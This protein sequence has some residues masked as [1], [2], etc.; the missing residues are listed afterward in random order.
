MSP[1]LSHLRAFVALLVVLA[2]ASTTTAAAQEEA[3]P[4][5]PAAEQSGEDIQTGDGQ[6]DSETA[7]AGSPGD[8][9]KKKAKKKGKRQ[10]DALPECVPE[11]AAVGEAASDGDA[12]ETG[13][14]D[15]DAELECVPPPRCDGNDVDLAPDEDEPNCVDLDRLN[16][17]ISQFEAA[18]AEETAALTEL[19]GALEELGVLNEQ[20]ELFRERLGDVQVRFASA[21]AD[22]GFAAIRQSI[23]AESFADVSAALQS[24]QDQL[25][26]QAVEAYM[27]G[28]TVELAT[29]TALLDI[30][31]YGDLEIA[32]E[33]A[34]VVIGDQV[35]TVDRVD[36][37]Q[38]GVE[39]L[40]RE[41]DLVEAD[42][43]ADVARVSEIEEQV[44]EL[45]AAQGDLVVGAEGEA[46]G[47]AEKISQI[48]QRK[49]VYAE[50][51][52]VQGA[53]GGAIG[54][55]LRARQ[56]EQDQPEAS[57]DLLVSPLRNT[58]IGS[59]FGP[60]IH[61]IFGDARLHAGVDMSGG[62]G[63]PIGAAGDGV[64]VFAEETE[65]YGNVVVVDH[66]NTVAT[67]YAHMSAG[68][69]FVGQE[70][71]EGDLVGFVGSTGYST[72][73][74]LHFEV[75]VKGT[76]VDPLLYFRLE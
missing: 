39:T 1:P 73:P 26:S 30:E 16:R 53:G 62:A 20:L 3:P 51:L 44:D 25:K 66:G 75:R 69:V 49:Q 65:G 29:A 12:R 15:L 21:R 38:L 14:S 32:R 64:V 24:E 74:H 71:Q 42:A 5:E 59:G 9:K 54:E 67:L 22:A 4:E 6:G 23:A 37:L 52:R 2:L 68:A 18:A 45:I 11:D 27:G 36:A 40:A 48:Q 55:L 76:P 17:L 72:G 34:S 46:A 43:A 57:A 7:E 13:S 47:V 70:L 35:A 33:Y 10:K 41:V 63:A 28:D 58:R 61:P 60:R 50:Q 8:T 19:S 31:G 56:A